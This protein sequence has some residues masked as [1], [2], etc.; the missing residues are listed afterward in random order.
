MSLASIIREFGVDYAILGELP[1][2]G[3]YGV[4][5]MGD[6]VK[7]RKIGRRLRMGGGHPPNRTLAYGRWHGP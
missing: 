1:A 4:A 5:L 3:S 2:I 7:Y 6:H